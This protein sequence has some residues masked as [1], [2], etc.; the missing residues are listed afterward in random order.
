MYFKQLGAM[1]LKMEEAPGSEQ[2]GI[3]LKI[4]LKS[5]NFKLRIN[6]ALQV[7]EVQSTDDNSQEPRE[8]H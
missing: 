2:Q 7:D 8:K 4:K 3:T 5:Q 1:L 6:M